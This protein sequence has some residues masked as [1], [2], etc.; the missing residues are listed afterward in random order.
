[1]TRH[2]VRHEDLA[3]KRN[4]SQDTFTSEERIIYHIDTSWQS[5]IEHFVDCIESGEPIRHGS[6]ADALRLMRIMDR[7]YANR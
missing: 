3:I 7:I 4:T 6:S 2:R 5:A 1:M